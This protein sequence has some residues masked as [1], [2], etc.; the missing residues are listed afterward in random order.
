MVRD[1]QINKRN[2]LYLQN[3]LI[4]SKRLD[5][6]IVFFQSASISGLNMGKRPDRL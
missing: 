6:G 2:D 1:L 3:A 4:A 5:H